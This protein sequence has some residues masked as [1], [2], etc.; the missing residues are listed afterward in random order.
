M[1]EQWKECCEGFYEVSDL[2]RVRRAKPGKTTWVGRVLKHKP[3]KR[4]YC[5]IHAVMDGVTKERKVHQLVAEA[6]LGP[7]PPGKE[8]NHKDTV[9]T[10]NKAS[11]LEYITH[12]GNL[13][14][15]LRTGTRQLKF[16]D[17]TV[18]LAKRLRLTGMSY[19]AIAD[20]TGMSKR[21]CMDVI[22]GKVRTVRWREG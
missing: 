13:L 21:H 10:N 5:R 18:D 2:G 14:H 19:Q 4:G 11:N 15:A 22:K 8:V 6:F 17:E 20:E 9:K 16:S 1:T 12:N 3:G 7:C